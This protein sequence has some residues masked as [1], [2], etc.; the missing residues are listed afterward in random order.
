V[1]RVAVAIDGEGTTWHGRDV[2]RSAQLPDHADGLR[3]AK[4]AWSGPRTAPGC[5][6]AATVVAR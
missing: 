2:R 5:R 1:T 3:A 6:I 4:V